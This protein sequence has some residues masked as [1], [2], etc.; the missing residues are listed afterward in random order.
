MWFPACCMGSRGIKGGACRSGEVALP[1]LCLATCG[2]QLVQSL[3]LL[4][5]A[6]WEMSGVPCWSW[7]DSNIR[8]PWRSSWVA[9]ITCACRPAGPTGH[10]GCHKRH[11]GMSLRVAVPVF[12]LGRHEPEVFVQLARRQQKKQKNNKKKNIDIRLVCA[13]REAG[14]SNNIGRATEIS[15]WHKVAPKPFL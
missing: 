12:V 7:S 3:L 8:F 13:G 11:R 9:C 1:M 2:R 14:T 4:R 6:P 5:F 10:A 15:N